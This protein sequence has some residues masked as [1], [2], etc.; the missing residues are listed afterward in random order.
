MKNLVMRSLIVMLSLMMG[1]MAVGCDD[2]SEEDTRVVA[3]KYR[4]FWADMNAGIIQNFQ[5]IRITLS[6]K[7]FYYANFNEEFSAYTDGTDLYVKGDLA[8]NDTP[9]RK[10]GTFQNDTTLIF[11]DFSNLKGETYTCKKQD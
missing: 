6:E 7:I 3:E 8:A 4:G 10:V 1:L 5:G 2:K 11:T 9:F